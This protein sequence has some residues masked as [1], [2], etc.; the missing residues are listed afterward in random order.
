MFVTAFDTL[1]LAKRLI[2]MGVPPNQA[3]GGAEILADIFNNHLQELATKEDLQREIGGL[4]K[5]TDVKYEFLR[6]DIDILRKDMDVKHEE[7][8]KEIH[9]MGERF[10]SK[11]EKLGLSLTIKH[12]LIT[13]AL[14]GAAPAFSKLFCSYWHNAHC[15]C[16]RTKAD[17]SCARCCSAWVSCVCSR[18]R[19]ATQAARRALPKPTARLRNQR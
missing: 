8:R 1:K 14:L 4:R 2:G 19:P 18:V 11:L 16:S 17:E 6:K 15:T 9:V 7:L 12:G 3:E 5:D 10:D 13:A